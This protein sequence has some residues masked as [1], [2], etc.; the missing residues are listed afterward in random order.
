MLRLP[1]LLLVAGICA[2]TSW[3]QTPTGQVTA[4][5]TSASP[6]SANMSPARLDRIDAMIE[7]AIAKEQVPGAVALIARHGKIV[8]HRAFGRGD[9]DGTPLDQDSIFRIA[10]QTKAITATAVMMLWEEG[11]FRLNDPLSKFLPEFANPQVLEA[12]DEA[13]GR[14][15]TRPAASEITIRQLITHNAGIGYGIIDRDPRM[16]QIYIDAGITDLFSTEAV[17]LADNVKKIAA[18]PLIFDP[19]KAFHYSEGLDIAGRLVEVVSGLPFDKFLQTHIFGPL[20]MTDTQFYL[21]PDQVD[22]LVTVQQPGADGGW[23]KYQGTE[24]YDADYPMK[25]ARTWFS[26]GAGLTSTVEDYVKFLQMYLNGG[27]YN[28]TR[29]LSRTTI[30]TIMAHQSDLA[31][32]SFFGIAFRVVNEAGGAEGGLGGIETFSGGGYFNTSYF[33]DPHEQLV[34]MIFKQT[35]NQK[36]DETSW[37]F[38]QLTFA[39]IDD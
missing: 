27:V 11:H 39:A 3:A 35:R 37:K 7:Q 31:D 15:I 26:G 10:S 25:G 16:K 17:V 38:M 32:T 33:A 1:S 13:T 5:L 2:V 18:L 12:Y 36:D 21:R 30:D 23:I 28:G 19:G 20:G 22:R 4:L 24:H 8:Y 6:E 9:P 14:Y 34:G 29:L